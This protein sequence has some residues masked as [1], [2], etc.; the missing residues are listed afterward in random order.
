MAAPTRRTPGGDRGS[1]LQTAGK[2]IVHSQHATAV[3]C[4][5]TA[6][7]AAW[8]RVRGDVLLQVLD[9]RT[10]EDVHPTTRLVVNA[11]LAGF[12]LEQVPA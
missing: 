9:G 8:A 10:V 7:Q 12:A 2:R 5:G 6:Q 11:L 1:A 4:A 3:D